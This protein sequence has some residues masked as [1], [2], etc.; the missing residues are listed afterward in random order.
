VDQ[1]LSQAQNGQYGRVTNVVMMGMG[2]PLFNFDN[3]V[4][5][6]NLM[7]DDDAYG[8]SKYRVTLST[9]GVIPA[10]E[11]TIGNEPSIIGSFLTCSE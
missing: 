11:K 3:V 7:L 4:A 6:L 2:E 10:M 9:A 1:Y 8:L 5:A